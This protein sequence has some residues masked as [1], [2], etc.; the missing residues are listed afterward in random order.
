MR[1]VSAIWADFHPFNALNSIDECVS[2]SDPDLLAAGDILIVHGGAD[3]SPALYNKG[4]SSRGAGA[5]PEPDRRDSVEWSM[6]QAAK[7]LG[8]PIIGICRG[9]QMLCAL[10]GGHL[11][12]HINGHGGT[13]EVTTFDKQKFLTNSIHHQQLVPAG[14]YQLVAWTET[15]S[16]EYWDVDEHG[17]DVVL[18]S[19]PLNCDPEFV[20]YPDVKGF[21]VQWHPEMMQANTRANQYVINFINSHV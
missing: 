7:R 9:A 11:I 2:F 13:H 1:L 4:L 12:Q 16:K 18:K 3:I 15:K 10:T 6:M 17:N 20:Y 8:V 19:N 5:W 21:A 14:N